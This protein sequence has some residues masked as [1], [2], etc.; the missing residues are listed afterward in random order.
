MILYGTWAYFR[1]FFQHPFPLKNQHITWSYCVVHRWSQT[2]RR[3]SVS[4]TSI[5]RDPLAYV[6][7]EIA[8]SSMLEYQ[9][10]HWWEVYNR[11]KECNRQ[12]HLLSREKRVTIVWVT[13]HQVQPQTGQ[14][15]PATFH[16]ELCARRYGVGYTGQKWYPETCN[17][18]S[19]RKKTGS[20]FVKQN[21]PQGTSVRQCLKF[22]LFFL[23]T[24]WLP[25]FWPEYLA[26]SSVT[27]LY[28]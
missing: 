4:A 17:W 10:F 26:F 12:L 9:Y 16:I 19:R 27:P 14:N 25:R 1:S 28:F 11:N 13:G 24:H 7:A 22:D 6:W 23:I 21:S 3:V 20:L 8:L 18:K 15:L 2:E 5:P